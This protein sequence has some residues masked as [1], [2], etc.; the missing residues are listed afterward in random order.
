VAELF[1][2]FDLPESERLAFLD[3][4]EIDPGAPRLVELC[5]EKGWHFEVLSDGFDVNIDHLRARFGVDFDYRSNHLEIG[6]AGW[7]LSP[8]GRPTDC[9]CGTGTCKRRV[10]EAFREASPDA[11]VVHVGNGR[12]SDLC[13]ALEADWAFAKDTLAPALDAAGRAHLRF[14]DLHEV[15]DDLE[16]W[17]V[18]AGD[19][20]PVAGLGA[21]RS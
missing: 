16:R 21:A 3:A 14:A 8:G 20:P 18:R 12:V 6:P 2:G 10:I 7:K 17:L 19:G 15:A 11:I 13:G 5:R 1:D 4:I 9:A